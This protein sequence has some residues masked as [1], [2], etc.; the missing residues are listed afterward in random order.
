MVEKGI[1]VLI[2][3]AFCKM[4]T[5]H[6][7]K[8]DPDIFLNNFKVNV[9]PVIRLTQKAIGI[10]RKNRSGKIIT[11]LTS[12]LAGNP[13][14]GSSEYVAAKAYLASLSKS[15]AVE[16]TCISSNCISPSFMKTQLTSN[17]DERVVEDMRKK[18]PLKNL[19][20][21]DEVADAVS[22]LVSASQQINGVNVVM[23]AATHIL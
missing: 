14:V 6:F 18:H 20:T 1:D 23:N 19:L 13:P 3:N 11:I 8:T 21:I 4:T 7:H 15:W 9:M 17:V 12:Y 5:S 16:N 22:F 10:F 2:N